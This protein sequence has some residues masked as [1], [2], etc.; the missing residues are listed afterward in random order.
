VIDLQKV[1]YGS[2]HMSRKQWFLV[3]I[4]KKLLI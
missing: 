1:A 3:E 2:F 4:S